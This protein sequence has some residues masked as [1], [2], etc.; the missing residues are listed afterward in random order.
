M[1][2]TIYAPRGT[3]SECEATITAQAAPD[4]SVQTAY[5]AG[6]AALLSLLASADPSFGVYECS[7]S[8]NDAGILDVMF[9]SFE[10]PVEEPST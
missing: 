7:V 4:A 8:G 9:G 6:K 3:K 1:I 2:W 5:A 10:A